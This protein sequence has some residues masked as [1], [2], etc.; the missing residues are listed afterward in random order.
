LKKA[1]IERISRNLKVNNCNEKEKIFE[2]PVDYSYNFVSAL[3]VSNLETR[4]EVVVVGG[5]REWTPDF[6]IIVAE[7]VVRETP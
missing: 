7:S 1:L 5:D 2:R 4:L 6:A 3:F